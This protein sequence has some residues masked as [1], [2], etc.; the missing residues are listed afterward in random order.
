MLW[1]SLDESGYIAVYDVEWPD[2]TV[3]RDIPAM[4]LEKV[5]DSNTDEAVHEAH[6]VEGHEEYSAIDERKYKK[7]KK[8]KAKKRKKKKHSLYPYVFGYG[9]HRDAEDYDYDIG[10]GDFGDVGGGFGD[11]GGGGE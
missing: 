9:Y 5:K 4:L 3:E 6:G 2:G 10:A 11:G 1:H 7:K 8:K